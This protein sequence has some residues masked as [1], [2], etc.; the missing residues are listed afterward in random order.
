[1][2]KDNGAGLKEHK[3]S[4]LV[5]RLK[6]ANSSLLAWAFVNIRKILGGAVA[7][8]AVALIGVALL[9]RSFLPPFNERNLVVGVVMQPGISLEESA[10]VGATAERL[11]M[12]IDGVESATLSSGEVIACDTICVAI[13]LIPS[14]ELIDADD[15]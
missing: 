8:V 14:I 13:G 3:D 1:M 10:R 11:I 5:T 2:G 6:S 4:R 15:S 12:G 7:L 9:P